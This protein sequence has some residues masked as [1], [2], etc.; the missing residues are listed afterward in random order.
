MILILLVCSQDAYY[1]MYDL[2]CNTSEYLCFVLIYLS[3]PS[4]NC[5]RIT[6]PQIGEVASNLFLFSP[7]RS[8]VAEH[9]CSD[10]TKVA[11]A[12]KNT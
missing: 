7:Y 10:G 12:F 11:E 5:Y 8:P 9:D 4:R 1:Q 6:T 2:T 3:N